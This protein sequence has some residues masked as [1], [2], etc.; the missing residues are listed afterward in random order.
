MIGFGIRKDVKGLTDER[1]EEEIQWV[2]GYLR[3][4][5]EPAAIRGKSYVR[6]WAEECRRELDLRAG[7]LA[8]DLADPSAE[9]VEVH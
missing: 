3:R 9:F 8:D 7:K 5:P 1:L 4:F 2:N 6:R